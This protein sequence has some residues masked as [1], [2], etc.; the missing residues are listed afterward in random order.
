MISEA[1]IPTAEAETSAA[2]FFRLAAEYRSKPGE[3]CRAIGARLAVQA[4]DFQAQATRL[5]VK[6][7]HQSEA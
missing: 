5:S 3:A 6:T 1:S 2:V 7:N 4:A